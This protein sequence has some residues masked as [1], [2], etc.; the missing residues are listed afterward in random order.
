MNVLFFMADNT[1]IRVFQIV[2]VEKE[3]MYIRRVLDIQYSR[4]EDIANAI[5]NTTNGHFLIL[6]RDQYST[7]P[8]YAIEYIDTSERFTMENKMA[9]V[10]LRE[11]GFNL[12][13]TPIGPV[14]IC[15]GDTEKHFISLKE[16]QIKI[17]E[18]WC[19]QLMLELMVPYGIGPIATETDLEAFF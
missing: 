8:I 3:S 10:I 9:E 1:T 12:S 4:Q 18:K 14:V 6:S 13:E 11:L 5:Y 7:K 16:K 15:A 17:L 2:P 19:K